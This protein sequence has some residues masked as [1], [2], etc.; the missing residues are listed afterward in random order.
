MIRWR[1]Y[2]DMT[3]GDGVEWGESE[4]EAL[5][6]DGHRFITHWL[7]RRVGGRLLTYTIPVSITSWDASVPRYIR[8]QAA[9]RLRL[10]PEKY[11]FPS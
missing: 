10:P 3:R 5:T 9:N 11:I 1:E 6:E 7:I 4:S 8:R 2:R